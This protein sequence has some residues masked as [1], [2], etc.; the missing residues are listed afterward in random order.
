MTWG[1]DNAVTGNNVLTGSLFEGLTITPKDGMP[2]DI[3][4]PKGYTALQ[5]GL[6]DG[7]DGK[8]TAVFDANKAYPAK[9]ADVVV[10]VPNIS[11]GNGT[12][13]VNCT[14]WS[15]GFT[16]TKKKEAM[17]ELNFTYRPDING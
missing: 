1:T 9:G 14:F 7:F 8:A 11:G 15:W 2:I 4:G 6:V 12:Q 16:R 13:N 10:L 5:V 17:I 3:E